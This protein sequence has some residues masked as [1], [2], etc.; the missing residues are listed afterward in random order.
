M[1]LYEALS[2]TSEM[3]LAYTG[4]G[5]YDPMGQGVDASEDALLTVAIMLDR[6]ADDWG[7]DLAEEIKKARTEAETN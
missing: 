3:I 2:R 7:L 5:N 6:V 4:D 1:K